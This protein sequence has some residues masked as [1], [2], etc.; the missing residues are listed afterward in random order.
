MKKALVTGI[1]GQDGAYLSKL[2]LEKGYK[3]FGTYRRTSSPNFWRIQNL[4]IFSKMNLIPADS[5][6]M[7]S[8]ME[9][10]K[11]SDPDEVYNLAASSFVS[12]A[13]EQPVGNAEITGLAVTKMLETIRFLN[14][15]IKFYQASSSEMYGNSKTK[16]QNEK[17]PFAPASPYAAAKLYAHWIT[18]MYKKAYNIFAVNGILFN[19]ESP[20]RGLEFVTRK[21]TNNVAE[22]SLGLKKE[23]V[24]GNINTKRDWGYAP[25][26]M[27]AIH[28]MLQQ[29]KPEDFVISTG[30]AHS[31]KD[32]VKLA[33]ELVGLD[34]KKYVK[35]DK[36][37]FRPLEIDYLKGNSKKAK[38]IL[39]WKPKTTFKNLVKIM[40][41]EDIKR[42][43][44]FL[45]GKTFPWDAPSYPSES[46]FITRLSD[47]NKKSKNNL[48]RKNS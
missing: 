27:E 39:G 25:E 3:V 23:L 28:L 17:T 2:L 32:F 21:I 41:D 30:E 35:K 47:E 9:A 15:N 34:W 6:D 22:I 11:V 16:S 12:T 48:K 29:D 13:F 44:M 36:R 37:Y 38:D 40:L 18:D 26:Y 33:F 42:W 4:E 7:G 10:I 43:K 14:P 1:T 20:L 24:L 45:D 19:H 5:L 31:V 8:M 46:K